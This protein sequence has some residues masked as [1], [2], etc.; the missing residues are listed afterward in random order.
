M[1]SHRIAPLDIS[2][3]ANLSFLKS[4]F[5]VVLTKFT[6]LD[7]IGR[8]AVGPRVIQVRHSGEAI[9][10]R[11]GKCLPPGSGRSVIVM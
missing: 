4:V 9:S 2:A 7:P 11:F 1:V 5:F 6:V 3:C 10:T 8:C